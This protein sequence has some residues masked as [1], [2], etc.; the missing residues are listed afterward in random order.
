VDL[1][2][3]PGEVDVVR[4]SRLVGLSLAPS[5]EFALLADLRGG[6]LVIGL[7]QGL[8]AASRAL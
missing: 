3:L 1:V 5:S 2:L 4:V 8:D 7:L 6:A